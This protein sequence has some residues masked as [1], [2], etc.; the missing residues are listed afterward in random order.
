MW[1]RHI[2][3]DAIPQYHRS[4]IANVRVDL[5]SRNVTEDGRK[6]RIYI[7]ASSSGNITRNSNLNTGWLLRT[8]HGCQIRT[9]RKRRHCQ[10]RWHAEVSTDL[11]TTVLL[12]Q[13]SSISIATRLRTGRSGNQIPVVARF[14]AP[15]HTG[16]GAHPASYTMGSGSFQG[17]K[18][19][20]RGVDHPPPYSAQVKERLELY[21]YSTSGPSWPVLGW[22]SPPYYLISKTYWG[23]GEDTCH[24]QCKHCFL[25]VCDTDYRYLWIAFHGS[26]TSQEEKI[27][28]HCGDLNHW[29]YGTCVCRIRRTF[30]S[31]AGT[32]R[33][34]FICKTDTK[35]PVT[36]TQKYTLNAC[37][38]PR[39]RQKNCRNR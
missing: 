32:W 17:V 28:R 21:L 24:I 23:G 4:Q 12:G 38:K 3:E 35:L 13:D 1:H 22:T 20:G 7:L 2:P 37:R 33:F 8:H 10:T 39:M 25:L 15:V 27:Y 5:H 34:Q 31:P 26:R 14:S 18:C 19:P 29:T 6:Q 9:T 16:Y 36:K 30:H 11:T